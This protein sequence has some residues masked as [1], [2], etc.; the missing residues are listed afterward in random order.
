MR[1][2][3]AFMRCTGMHACIRLFM[4]PIPSHC[5]VDY[6][7]HHVQLC[8]LPTL[9]HWSH[10]ATPASWPVSHACRDQVCVH[11]CECETVG[12]R[13]AER[14]RERV[15]VCVVGGGAARQAKR[16][17]T[18]FTLI[19]PSSSHVTHHTCSLT[20]AA[21]LAL[22]G[23]CSKRSRIRRGFDSRTRT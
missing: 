6:L 3:T 22:S 9:W 19:A 23:S 10:H 1:V 18:V 7:T 15:C 2:Y 8:G 13:E 14:E 21:S 5:E 20:H 11:A 16:D 17:I 4:C 12:E